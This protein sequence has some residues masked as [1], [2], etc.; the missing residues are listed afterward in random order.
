MNVQA[1][2]LARTRTWSFETLVKICALLFGEDVA[3]Q[4]IIWE[5]ESDGHT[6]EYPP[7]LV[8]LRLSNVAFLSVYLA[9][10]HIPLGFLVTPAFSSAH[11]SHQTREGAMNAASQRARQAGISRLL[12]HHASNGLPPGIAT[13]CLISLPVFRSFLK[14]PV[15]FNDLDAQDIDEWVDELTSCVAGDAL[16]VATITT[17]NSRGHNTCRS[18]VWPSVSTFSDFLL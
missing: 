3:P 5:D 9:V 11:A 13:S 4:S 17:T 15:A 14:M 6:G 12:F 2:R 10:I 18:K 1:D 16:D 8:R 7:S